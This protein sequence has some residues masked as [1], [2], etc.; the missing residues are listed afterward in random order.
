MEDFFSSTPL[1]V[2]GRPILF[3]EEVEIKMED[4]VA[5]MLQEERKVL[6]ELSPP[7]MVILI[8]IRL[9]VIAKTNGSS[10][11]LSAGIALRGWVSDIFR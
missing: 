2:V 11:N 9:I 5:I 1:S 3:D 7:G 8:N 10:T 4:G 6:S